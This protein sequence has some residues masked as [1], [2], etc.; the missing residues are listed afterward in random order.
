MTRTSRTTVQ[1]FVAMH[2]QR[3]TGM[4]GT[5]IFSNNEPPG[6][7]K[8]SWNGA[9]S[10]TR[11]RSCESIVRA[12]HPPTRSITRSR[13]RRDAGRSRV[14]GACTSVDLHTSAIDTIAVYE[15]E[16]ST[17][18]GWLF[19]LHACPEQNSEVTFDLWGTFAEFWYLLVQ[20]RWKK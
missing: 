2:M 14:V 20:I 9:P 7:L 11:L 10:S 6:P 17:Q 15:Y 5:F 4:H 16:Y 13:T 1:I 18:I 8:V 3:H 19:S 12:A